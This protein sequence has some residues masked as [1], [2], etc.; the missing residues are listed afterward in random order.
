MPGVDTVHRMRKIAGLLDGRPN[1]VKLTRQ[2]LS[3]SRSRLTV[4]GGTQAAGT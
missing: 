2:W 1:V 4:A 3:Y